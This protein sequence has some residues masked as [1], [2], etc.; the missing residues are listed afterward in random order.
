MGNLSAQFTS[1]RQGTV[2]MWAR[3]CRRI[4][5]VGFLSAS[6]ALG[7]TSLPAQEK[8]EQPKE[9]PAVQDFWLKE[10]GQHTCADVACIGAMPPPGFMNPWGVVMAR[11][12]L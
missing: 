12:R 11:L 9:A 4:L 5:V 1:N 6:F 7:A 2:R 8:I 10:I 3:S